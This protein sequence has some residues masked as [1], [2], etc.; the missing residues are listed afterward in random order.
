M[1]SIVIYYKNSISDGTPDQLPLS[2]LLLIR[3]DDLHDK[4]LEIRV[5]Y[6]CIKYYF[7]DH[8]LDHLDFVRNAR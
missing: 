5:P 1:N 3:W 4:P 8:F 2:Q 6:S 7:P